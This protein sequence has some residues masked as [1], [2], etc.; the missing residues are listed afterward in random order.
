MPGV[1][2]YTSLV[3]LAGACFAVGQSPAG[4]KSPQ[5]H[6]RP[7]ASSRAAAP[8]AKSDAQIEA[9]IRARF[10]KSKIDMDHFTVH[11]QGGVATIEGRTDVIQHKGVATRLAKTAGAAA[12]NNRVQPSE[13]AR[14]KAAANLAKGRRRIQVKRGDARSEAAQPRGKP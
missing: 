1:P 14:S 4:S 9:A 7:A 2:I 8:A 5:A 6:Q 10:A 13:A 11:V 12:V 3:L